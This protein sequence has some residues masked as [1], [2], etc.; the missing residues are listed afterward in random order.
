MRPDAVGDQREMRDAEADED[1]RQQADRLA[2][3]AQVQVDQQHD[4]G[5]RR[6]QLHDLVHRRQQAEE[7]VDA[8]R[9]RDRDRQHVVD[10]QCGARDETR[11]GTDELGRHLVAAA[12]VRKQLDDLVVGQRDH[13]HCERGRHGEVQRELVVRA[14]RHE[15]FGGA[16]RRGGQ[17]VGADA[18]PGEEC[19]ERDV[20]ARLG[21]HRV[22]WRPEDHVAQFLLTV[23]VHFWRMAKRAMESHPSPAS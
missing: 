2:H 23:R 14:E 9:R 17:A 3:P 12:A 7:R 21:R 6:L 18:D 13:E 20:L 8:A 4:H 22:A 19:G 10:D 1:R 5:D 16:V 15:R 11:V